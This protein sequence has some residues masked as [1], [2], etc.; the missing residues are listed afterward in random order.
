MCV[1][2]GVFMSE[3]AYIHYIYDEYVSVRDATYAFLHILDMSLLFWL[4][5]Y[6]S[7]S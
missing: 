4:T 7:L 1:Q 6:F 2:V 3:C 5:N